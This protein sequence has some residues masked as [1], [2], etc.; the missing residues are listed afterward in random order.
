MGFHQGLP[1]EEPFTLDCVVIQWPILGLQV[2]IFTFGHLSAAGVQWFC[3]EWSLPRICYALIHWQR[4]AQTYLLLRLRHFLWKWPWCLDFLDA[5]ITF[6]MLG[7]SVD[8]TLGYNGYLVSISRWQ[9]QFCFSYSDF[10]IGKKLP[11]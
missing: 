9:C 5:C 1:I 8:E 3:E 4:M 2:Y 6:W 7:V 11:I 10:P